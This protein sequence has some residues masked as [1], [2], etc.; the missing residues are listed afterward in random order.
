MGYDDN[1]PLTGVTGGGL[2]AEIWR[3]T[4]E[5]VHAGRDIT[6]LPGWSADDRLMRVQIPLRER[7]NIPRGEG[8]GLI[9]GILRGLLRPGN[10]AQ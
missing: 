7:G 10:A 6:P 2:P 5:K 4:M 1:T 8:P 3:R 9:E